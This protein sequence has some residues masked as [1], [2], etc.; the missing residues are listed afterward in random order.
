[1][2]LKNIANNVCFE[3][4]ASLISGIKKIKIINRKQGY[5]KQTLFEG[6]F[7]EYRNFNNRFMRDDF[8]H[9]KVNG[10]DAIDDILVIGIE[11][12]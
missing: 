5:D 12:D 4:I 3:T 1:M 2:R 9:C 7:N 11:H 8:S 10:I 6:T